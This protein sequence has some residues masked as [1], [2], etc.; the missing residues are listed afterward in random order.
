MNRIPVRDLKL[1]AALM[2]LDAA[3]ALVVTVWA[4]VDVLSAH[5]TSSWEWVVFG[6]AVTVG[7]SAGALW[8]RRRAAQ[9]QTGG[10]S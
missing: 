9:A 5:P 1:F 7:A 3:V 8:L 10:A 6:T 4:V 2:A